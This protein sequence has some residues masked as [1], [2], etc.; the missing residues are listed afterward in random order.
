MKI[1]IL[2]IGNWNF[3]EL[4]KNGSFFLKNKKINLNIGISK[5]Y[6]KMEFWKLN[7]RKRNFEKLFENEIFENLIW[8]NWSF[9]NLFEGGVLKIKF[10]IVEFWKIKFK[11]LNLGRLNLKL[12]F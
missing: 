3:E 1:W 7:L 5:N 10:G 12:E 4:F 11:N 6:L 9:E 8:R 2:E